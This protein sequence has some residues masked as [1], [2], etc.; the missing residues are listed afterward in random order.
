MSRFF[1]PLVLAVSAL[2]VLPA[3]AQGPDLRPK[4]MVTGEGE[5]RISPDMAIIALAVMREGETAR[6][7]MDENNAAMAAVIAALK[8]EGIEARDLQTSGLSIDPQYVYPNNNNG[9]EKPRITGYRVTNTLTVRVRDLENVGEI[10]DRS[11]SL[12]VN[13][14]GNITFT[15]D[16][17]SEALSQARTRAVEDAVAKARTLAEAA[18]VSLGDV[19]QLSEQSAPPPRPLA[20]PVMRMEAAADKAVPVETGENTYSVQ[21]NVTFEIGQE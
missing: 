7:A 4:I 11:V 18:G 9:E 1:V 5:A 3:A 14:G 2:A 10:L 19:L 12:G 15:N 17:P 13:Q 6:E 16:N 20:A 21:V 8:E